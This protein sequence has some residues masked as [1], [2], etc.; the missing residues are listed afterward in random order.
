[1]LLR[2]VEYDF[3]RCLTMTE[4]LS[5]SSFVSGSVV[6]FQENFARFSL[7]EL[8]KSL[9]TLIAFRLDPCHMVASVGVISE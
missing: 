2:S 6:T 8:K 9:E 7:D 4:I 1:M 5:G 3:F